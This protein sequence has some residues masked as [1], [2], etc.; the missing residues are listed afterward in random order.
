MADMVRDGTRKGKCVGDASGVRRHPE[1]V[2]RGETSGTA[3]LRE[4]DVIGIR[5]LAASGVTHREIAEQFGV[6]VFNISAVVRRKTWKHV[7]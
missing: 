1:R 4:Q 6:T 5:S 7:P 3:K 2:A